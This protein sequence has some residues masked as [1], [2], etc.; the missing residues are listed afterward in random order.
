MAWQTSLLRPV[1]KIGGEL[2][3]AEEE[4]MQLLRE[5]TE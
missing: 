4:I 3:G 2:K 1:E 5:V